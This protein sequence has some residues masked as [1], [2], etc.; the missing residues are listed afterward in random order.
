MAWQYS[1]LSHR[2]YRLHSRDGTSRG[3]GLDGSSSQDTPSANKCLCTVGTFIISMTFSLYDRS[4][5]LKFF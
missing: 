4:C 3:G 5:P 2:G 1:N